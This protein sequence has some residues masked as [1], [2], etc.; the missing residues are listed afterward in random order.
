MVTAPAEI[1]SKLPSISDA[2]RSTPPTPLVTATF[3]P[4][5]KIAPVPRLFAPLFTVMS[6][7]PALNESCPPPPS[8]VTTPV[9]RMSPL[10]PVVT[11]KSVAV[12]VPRV[13]SFPLMS[14]SLIVTDAPSSETAP[15]NSL[16]EPSVM[17]P[18]PASNDA[19]S[20]AVITSAP[21]LR[22]LP[23]LPVV[24]TK[25]P[26]AV[27]TPSVSSF[28]VASASLIVT[29]VPSR[30]TT[31]LNSFTRLRLI[32]PVV[33]AVN[34]A[35]PATIV[36]PANCVMSP[37]FVV[38]T[39]R[40]SPVLTASR[41]IPPPESVILTAPSAL[42]LTAPVKSFPPLRRRMTLPA[43]PAVNDESVSISKAPVAEILPSTVAAVKE[44]TPVLAKLISSASVIA[45]VNPASVTVPNSLSTSVNVISPPPATTSRF[46]AP[47]VSTICAP[48]VCVTLPPP[49]V[50]VRS[51]YVEAAD[52]A[53]IL[54]PVDTNAKLPP[55]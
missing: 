25:S 12:T 9:A 47:P 52:A 19:V 42:R 22:M 26:L 24:T 16:A 49:V 41:I 40:V 39:V 8:I 6:P 30:L 4:V 55:A 48:T 53:S 13:S 2:P 14:A 21:L 1:R 29:F 18:I 54:P 35:S 7:S 27:T 50:S 51:P 31:P 37:A 38:V 17:S 33:S 44:S 15:S 32:F 28:P 20:A 43:P 36:P 5:S 46:V 23:S 45:T 11:V 10:L 3:V 34:V